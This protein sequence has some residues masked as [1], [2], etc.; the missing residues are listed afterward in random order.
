MGAE[1]YTHEFQIARKSS[2]DRDN[3][4]KSNAIG[5]NHLRNFA[6][7]LLKYGKKRL[8]TY[9]IR[10]VLISIHSNPELMWSSFTWMNPRGCG[11]TGLARERREKRWLG[12][13]V[14]AGGGR[15]TKQYP[16][17][18]GG[19]GGGRGNAGHDPPIKHLL[20]EPPN[21]LGLAYTCHF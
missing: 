2:Q 4:T 16:F 6:A 14:S 3:H 10:K 11:C 20:D 15:G 8:R 7:L 21:R 18:G 5:S 9:G 13:V 19:G 12:A 1:K 17:L